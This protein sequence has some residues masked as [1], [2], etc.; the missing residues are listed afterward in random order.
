MSSKRLLFCVLLTASS[1]WGA[2][3]R[4]H[5]EPADIQSLDQKAIEKGAQH[6]KQQCLVCHSMR[7]LTHDEVATKAGISLETMPMANQNWTFA[8][9]PPD[10]SLTSRS[11]G[12]D[13]ITTYLKSYYQD[14]T[15]SH[16][17]NNLLMPGTSMPNPFIAMQG[18]QVKVDADDLRPGQ[19]PRVHNLVM[20]ASKGSMNSDQFDQHVR[21]IVTFLHYAAEPKKAERIHLGPYVLLFL[22]L[23]S[24]LAFRLKQS[25]W[26]DVPK[27]RRI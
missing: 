15:I 26:Q 4:L 16:G 18:T 1:A 9:P 14:D 20:L 27:N 10:L 8:K 7:Y 21:E 19:T 2:Q 13:W 17:F 11:R 6:F 23:F 3:A 22:L 25:Y 12:D 5:L 24:A